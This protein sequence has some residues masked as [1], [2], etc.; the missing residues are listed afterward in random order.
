LK[1]P[2]SLSLHCGYAGHHASPSDLRAAAPRVARAKR[3]GARQD[4]N[5]QPDRYEQ[6]DHSGAPKVF[7]V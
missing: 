5:L 2:S 4:S 3:G 1:Q 7:F 6:Q